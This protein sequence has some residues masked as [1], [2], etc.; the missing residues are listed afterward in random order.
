MYYGLFVLLKHHL[1]EGAPVQ[2][3][4]CGQY[5]RFLHTFYT[6]LGRYGMDR[7][8]CMS[9]PC[10]QFVRLPEACRCRPTVAVPLEIVGAALSIEATE[11]SCQKLCCCFCCRQRLWLVIP[12][13][14]TNG[15]SQTTAVCDAASD[16]F[17]FLNRY[18]INISST[19]AMFAV[20]LNL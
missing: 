13:E 2:V 19:I 17:L 18:I 4:D 3:V 5:L 8:I 1:T 15:N 16:F 9:L 12:M 20:V 6:L 14:N 11:A 10:F 7:T